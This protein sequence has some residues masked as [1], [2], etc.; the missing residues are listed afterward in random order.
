[1]CHQARCN[2][3]GRA[4]WWG[5]GRH[6]SKVMNSIPR[7]Q[8]CICEPRVERN[9]MKYPPKGAMGSVLSEWSFLKR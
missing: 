1:M 9:G 5:C 4:T 3:C 7:E 8:W 2:T 6:I